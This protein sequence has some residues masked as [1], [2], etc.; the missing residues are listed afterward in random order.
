[1]Y[2]KLLFS[3]FLCITL[4]YSYSQIS[5]EELT[6][7]EQELLKIQTLYSKEHV[8]YAKAAFNL[9]LLYYQKEDNEDEGLELATIALRFIRKKEGPKGSLYTESLAKLNNQRALFIDANLAIEAI[10]AAGNRHS[11]AY[12]MALLQQAKAFILSPDMDEAHSS[13]LEAYSILSNL[14]KEESAPVYD[15]IPK[16]LSPSL[17]SFIKKQIRVKEALL[18]I[19]N[20]IELA[21]RLTIFS[22]ESIGSEIRTLA[23]EYLLKGESEFVC[24]VLRDPKG[25]YEP[26][27]LNQ[28][29]MVSVLPVY[30]Y[31]TKMLEEGMS[32]QVITQNIKTKSINGEFIAPPPGALVYMMAPNNKYYDF[33]S[34]KLVDI[35]PHIMMYFPKIEA[36]SIGFNGQ[37]GIP[38]F[39]QEYPH[40]SV[41][42]IETD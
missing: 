23:N 31:Q 21:D 27:C 24:L 18:T 9:A 22:E 38:G 39:Y 7:A 10:Q 33:S 25:R 37:G 12:V 35:K 8:E 19:P 16:Y 14:S 4:Q 41:V 13:A 6:K 11:A 28:A 42:H 5:P 1:M 2:T 20:T 3:L 29:A 32:I 40:L 17:I 26:S 15:K 30:E 36:E 34:K